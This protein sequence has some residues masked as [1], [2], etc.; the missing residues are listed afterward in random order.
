MG[1]DFSSV[2]WVNFM[3]L[4]MKKDLSSISSPNPTFYPVKFHLGSLLS[5][6]NV[7]KLC[8]L[9]EYPKFYLENLT[10]TN[11]CSHFVKICTGGEGSSINVSLR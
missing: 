5:T 10:F 4:Y 7:L 11:P 9:F 6:F 3:I 8:F 1:F 2:R